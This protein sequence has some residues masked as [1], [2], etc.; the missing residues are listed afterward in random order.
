MS[1]NTIQ[2]NAAIKQ[3]KALTEKST[4]F[5]FSFTS[6]SEKRNATA[7]IVIVRSASLRKQGTDHL[8]EYRDHDKQREKRC[9][10]CLLMTFNN[11][12]IKI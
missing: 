6:F 12:Q 9:Y 2:L 5:R 3:M 4:P 10:V 7:G 11:K 1:S 8:L